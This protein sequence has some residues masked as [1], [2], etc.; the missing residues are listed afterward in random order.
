MSGRCQKGSVINDICIIN[1]GS[2]STGLL[3]ELDYQT[4]SGWCP[5]LD[6][7]ESRYPL[8][9][10]AEQPGRIGF[11]RK[12]QWSRGTVGHSVGGSYAGG[13]GLLLHQSYVPGPTESVGKMWKPPQQEAS[14]EL[15]QLQEQRQQYPHNGSAYPGSVQ[16]TEE[17]QVH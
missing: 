6:P 3:V 15:C 12:L 10:I 13:I 9:R 14:A 17:L 7:R 2:Q 5:L 16:A 4:S 8:A 11:R 1:M